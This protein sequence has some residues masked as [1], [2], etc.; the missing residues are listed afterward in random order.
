MIGPKS[1]HLVERAA[2]RLLQAGV[3]EGSAAQLLEPD[4][5]RPPPSVPRPNGS[6]PPPSA[7]RRPRSSV[8]VLAPDMPLGEV[9]GAGRAA[10]RAV[11]AS[12]DRDGRAGSAP[13]CSTGRTGAAAFPRNSAW[14]SARL[15]RAA[16]APTAEAGVS[17]LV[18]VTSARPG[19][20][21]T[22]T[23]VNLAGSVALARRSPRAADRQRFQAGFD[24]PGARSGRRAGRARPWPPTRT[25]T[26][27]R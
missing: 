4:R 27:T 11:A 13:A 12:V 18:M 3:L 2:E 23:A 6:D 17:N 14:R 10:C 15:L 16:F 21:K 20:G 9:R 7:C 5:L 26:P 8:D 25:S 24:L 22:F 1:A 19:E